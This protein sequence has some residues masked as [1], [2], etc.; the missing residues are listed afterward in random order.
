[1]YIINFKEF[2]I[3]FNSIIARP[4]APEIQE[5]VDVELPNDAQDS[6]EFVFKGSTHPDVV[7]AGLCLLY[8]NHVILNCLIVGLDVLR[9]ENTFTDVRIKV[10]EAEFP[11]HKCVLSSFSPYFKA[12]FTAG[13]AETAQDVVTLNGVE[14]TMISGQLESVNQSFNKVS[15]F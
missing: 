10:E 5:I 15:Q 12:M 6:E 3:F 4:P 14:P 11:V 8:T 13:L 7:L 9:K 1:M 2:E